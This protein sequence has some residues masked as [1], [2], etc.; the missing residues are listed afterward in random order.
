LYNGH[1]VSAL[2]DVPLVP[3]RNTSS[4]DLGAKK[5]DDAELTLN[6]VVEAPRWTSAQMALTP[7]QAFAPIRQ[8]LRRRRLAYVRN[9][10]PHRGYI[11]NYGALPQVRLRLRVL[12][13]R[14]VYLRAQ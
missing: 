4:S 13:Q 8:K 1:T 10:F 12:V 3:G 2:H 7:V 9:C 11:W 14:C 5:D 6:M